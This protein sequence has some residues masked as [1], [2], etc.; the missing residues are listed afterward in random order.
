M[1]KITA[2]QWDEIAADL[3][4]DAAGLQTFP[5]VASTDVLAGFTWN[6]RIP[7]SHQAEGYISWM[8][9]ALKESASVVVVKGSEVDLSLPPLAAMSRCLHGK[10]DLVV[11]FHTVHQTP[12]A[13]SGIIFVMELKKK[14]RRRAGLYYV[15][16]PS[17]AS[18]PGRAKPRSTAE[19]AAAGGELPLQATTRRC[20]HGPAR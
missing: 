11:L 13:R 20:A 4:I 6:Q 18:H 10:S 9:M 8:R 16:F 12:E 19:G 1:S 14:V 3:G 2:T 15:A 7:E 17:L 5:D